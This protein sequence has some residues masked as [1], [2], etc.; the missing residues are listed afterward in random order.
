MPDDQ[1]FVCLVHLMH[2][3]QLRH[4]FTP[5]MELL[6]QRLFVFDRLLAELL[7]KVNDHLTQEG[8]RSTMY[9]SQ[10]FLT[11]FAYKFPLEVVFR[12]LDIMFA[13]GQVPG[14][15]N[16]ESQGVMDSML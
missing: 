10:W 9:A 1:A 7:P 14:V 8:V 4:Q 13:I 3:Y 15:C 6:Q 2:T 16:S 12:L 5:K 11:L